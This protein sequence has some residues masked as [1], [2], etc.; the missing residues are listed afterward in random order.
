MNTAETFEYEKSNSHIEKF[1]EYYCKLPE[2]PY[3]SILLKGKW[4]SGK[5]WFIKNQIKKLNL[6]LDNSGPA[7]EK[8]DDNF[9]YVSLYGMNDCS[10]I[11]T[12]FFKQLHP[13]LSH[14]GVLLAG[15][16]VKG[17]FRGALKIDLD[18]DGRSD[19]N[20]QINIPNLNI[21]EYLTNSEHKILIFDDLERCCIPI[22]EVLG[23]INAYVEHGGHKVIIIANEEEIF[24]SSERYIKIKEKLIGKTFEII[25]ER[26]KACDFFIKSLPTGDF[27]NF[28]KKNKDTMLT[29]HRQ[30][31][32]ENLR[33]LKYIISDFQRF[34]QSLANKFKENTE[35]MSAILFPFFALSFE[36]KSGK[37]TQLELEELKGE[38]F[39]YLV[40]LDKQKSTKNEAP[41][42]LYSELS[43]KYPQ[44][45]LNELILPD[46]LWSDLLCKNSINTLEIES[47]LSNSKYVLKENKPSWLQLWH[48]EDLSNSEF[49]VLLQ[50][51]FKEFSDQPYSAAEE[52]L[53]IAGLL[54]KFSD[55][56]LLNKS[57]EAIFELA[58]KRIEWH[59]NEGIIT[60]QKK[61]DILRE[62]KSS[63]G[64]YGYA[65]T[66]FEE[67][68][69]LKKELN[70]QRISAYKELFPQ[71]TE[72][73]LECLNTNDPWLFYRQLTISNSPDQIYWD[74]PL[75]LQIVPSDFVDKYVSI[76]SEGKSAMRGA[77]SQRYSS[78]MQQEKLIS[79]LPWLKELSTACHQYQDNHSKELSGFL[80]EHY[81]HEVVKKAIEGL[82]TYF[83]NIHSQDK[84]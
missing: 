55:L 20:A 49:A 34:Y 80:V 47:V 81:L 68:N 2:S 52:L 64:G 1:L 72:K 63:W 60:P 9:L 61:D 17:I 51:V 27:L 41:A 40:S 13:V 5:T 22:E 65:G 11:E 18:G 57:K 28:C 19:G 24:N 46:T 50:K 10:Q 62:W 75:L 71:K 29:L 56:G 83:S 3:Y 15:K 36:L 77:I 76:S 12:E 58:K 31:E 8:I 30:S 35:L 66:E 25:A 44:I 82:E 79:E 45:S 53:H 78:S 37:L 42:F 26:E 7:K 4:G 84:Q 32:Y 69:E 33:H 21:S 43:R 54:F 67:F 6:I 73:L 74:V 38:Y 16:I 70:E 23:F 14:K 59:I 39:K 48:Y